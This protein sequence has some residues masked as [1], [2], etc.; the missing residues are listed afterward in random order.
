MC[1]TLDNLKPGET[2]VIKKIKD[3]SKIKRRL[4]DIGLIPGTIVECILSSPSN[5]SLAYLIRGTTIAIRKVDSKE[6]EVIF[7]D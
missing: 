5:D 4:L 7:N 6:I 2:C 3:S 1:M